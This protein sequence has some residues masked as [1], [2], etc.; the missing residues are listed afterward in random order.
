MR[1][2]IVFLIKSRPHEGNILLRRGRLFL[3]FVVNHFVGIE[4]WMVRYFRDHQGT[5]QAELYSGL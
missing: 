3:Q 2:Y 1:E 5:L 4:A